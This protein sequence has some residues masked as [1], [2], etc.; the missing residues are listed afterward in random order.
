[1]DT[2]VLAIGIRH[3][4]ISNQQRMNPDS[5][6]VRTLPANP[7]HRACLRP[8]A[9]GQLSP[10]ATSPGRVVPSRQGVFS[11]STTCPAALPVKPSSCPPGPA[12]R[13]R[14]AVVQTSARGVHGPPAPDRTSSPSRP[15]RFARHVEIAVR[16]RLLHRAQVLKPAEQTETAAPQHGPFCASES[17]RR[18]ITRQASHGS[19]V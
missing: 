2:S 11:F 14:Q 6:A 19:D 1:M 12:P 13:V 5:R 8:W 15:A 16:Q 10:A 18:L 17:P 4:A 3:S 7:G 9:E